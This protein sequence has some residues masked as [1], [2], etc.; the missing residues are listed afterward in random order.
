MS[1]NP[2]ISIIVPIYNVEKYLE[3]CVDSLI[4]QDYRPIEIILVDDCSTDGSA[5]IAKKY[6]EEY[7]DFCFLIQRDKNGGLSAARNSGMIVA[8]GDWISFVD[9]DDW[10]SDDYVSELAT[11]AF[12]S[13]ADVVLGNADYVYDSGE[14]KSASAFGN[15]KPGADQKEIIALCRS[16]AWGR[17]FKTSLFMDGDISFPEDIKR[18][19]DIGTIIPILTKSKSIA[20]L[21]KSIYFY[22]QRSNSLSNTNKNIDLAFY[23][24][25]LQRMFDLSN[26]GYEEELEF[27]AVHEMLYGMVYLMVDSDKPKND[28]ITH[29][30]WF[31]EKFPNWKNNKYL[32]EL[33]RAKRLFVNLAGSKRYFLIKMLVKARK[34]ANK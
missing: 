9:S 12:K 17:L 21:E 3:K 31:N 4:K 13:S 33:P 20:L 29:V 15:L 14:M 5:L 16:Y 7:P 1:N 28:F 8:K 30:N 32:T 23:P 24:K 11:T 2:L 6:A 25:T 18:S 10:V 26:S 34:T 27:R 19:E 22:Y